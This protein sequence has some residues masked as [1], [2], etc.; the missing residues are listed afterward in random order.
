MSSKISSYTVQSVDKALDILDI[1]SE[2]SIH[3]TLQN[4]SDRLGISRN[5]TFR[6]LATL[7]NRGLVERDPLSGIYHL[8][9]A[10][11]EV[12]HR[13][14]NSASIIRYAHPVMEGL[15][16]KHDEAVYMTVMKGDEVL[17]LDMVDCGQQ[18]KAAPFLGKRFP[19]FTNAAGKVIKSLESRDLLEK[20]FKRGREKKKL[21][22]LVALESELNDIREKGVAIESG[23]LGEGIITVAVAVRDYAG[24]VIG[25][26][27]MLG[28]S[29]RMV[30][31]RVENEIIPSLREQ[32]EL[33]SMKFGYART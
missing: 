9:L 10:T 19:F 28:P 26:L 33:L 18:I 13:F 31:E 23:G 8:G 7:E 2:G 14:I 5:K 30:T 21:P 12:A 17:F 15:A 16:R 4:L 22:D 1:L 20:L 29:F 6:L 11:V 25:A 27:T 32:A 24:K 3:A